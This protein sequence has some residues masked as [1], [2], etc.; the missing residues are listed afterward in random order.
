[1][2]HTIKMLKM[3]DD[4]AIC[5]KKRPSDKMT[6]EKSGITAQLNKNLVRFS[7][8]CEQIVTAGGPL[9]EAAKLAAGSESAL[10][11]APTL[12]GRNDKYEGISREVVEKPRAVVRKGAGVL[13]V[14]DEKISQTISDSKFPMGVTQK[15][16]CIRLCL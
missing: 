3:K 10:P 13:G 8:C 2:S 5:M 7:T 4:P 1:M 14:G 9:R 6:V 12:L 15:C 11:V 16:R